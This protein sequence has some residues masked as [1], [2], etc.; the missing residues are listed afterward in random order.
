MKKISLF[1]VLVVGVLLFTGC[2]TKNVEGTLEEI[3]T[4]IYTDVYTDVPEEE[5]PMLGD[6]D[7]LKD[8]PD[9]IEY[10]IG[11]TDI[12]YE[13]IYAREPMMG[14]IAYSVVLVRMK[15]GADIEAAKTKIAE[16][17]NPRKW[18]CV[19]VAKEDVIVKNK[20][21]LIILIMVKD[22]ATRTKI[23]QGFNNL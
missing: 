20:G 14:S 7:V 10:Y 8:A 16:T 23:E 5:R 13:E 22:E 6:I 4:K 11:T 2:G 18:I 3:M 9:N 17:V 12:E 19:E 21:D 15:D 1:I